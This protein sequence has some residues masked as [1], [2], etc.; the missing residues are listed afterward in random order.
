MKR[1]SFAVL[2]WCKATSRKT[3]YSG[4]KQVTVQLNF[5]VFFIPEVK[6]AE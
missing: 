4:W 1:S 2:S 3:Q 5:I 6:K